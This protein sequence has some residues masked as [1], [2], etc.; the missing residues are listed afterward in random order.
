MRIEQPGKKIVHLLD[1]ARLP[2][3]ESGVLSLQRK[4]EHALCCDK[5]RVCH[6]SMAFC[7][8]V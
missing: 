3:D 8:R 2:V 6:R 1:L 7:R 5:S 4:F